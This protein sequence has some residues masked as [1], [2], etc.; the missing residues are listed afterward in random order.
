MNN[1]VVS[2]IGVLIVACIA[3]ALQRVLRRG[4]RRIHSHTPIQTVRTPAVPPERSHPGPLQVR[5]LYRNSKGKESWYA[6]TMLSLKPDDTGIRS[7]NLRLHGETFVKAFLIAGMLEIELTDQ[8][9]IVEGSENIR[10]ELVRRLPIGSRRS[11]GAKRARPPAV[12]AHA[13]PPA[14]GSPSQLSDL[15][16]PNARGFAVL[17][18]ETTALSIHSARIVEI[19]I[20][21]VDRLGR[22]E[23]EWESLV[24]PGTAITNTAIHGIDERMVAQAPRFGELAPMIAAKLQGR[25]VVAHNLNAYDLPIL[26]RHLAE[27][28]NLNIDLGLGIDTMPSPRQSLQSLCRASGLDHDAGAAHSALGDSRALAALLPRRISSLRR[29]GAMVAVKGVLPLAAPSA[30][31]PRHRLKP[32]PDAMRTTPEPWQCSPLTL[33]EGLV[34]MATGPKS[35]GKNT[36][37]RR[38]E[39]H[40]ESLGLT[41]QRSNTIPKR[42]VP[43]FLLSTSLS[44]TSTKMRAAM[45]RGIPVVLASDLMKCR[46]GDSVP[47]HR[48]KEIADDALA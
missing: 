29:G 36:V 40:G 31:M 15:L 38:A 8:K 3:L 19:A 32:E 11:N 10:R 2:V 12:P 35:T 22:I 46:R 5:V 27:F 9:E 20:V 26:K 43:A 14:P 24:Q 41:Y 1:A 45:E 7:V 17:D 30:G 39:A 21:H 23:S 48:W 33:D 28:P 37:I 6:G 18:L 44:L 42:R 4:Q 47:A 13:D 34:F 16:P 25:V